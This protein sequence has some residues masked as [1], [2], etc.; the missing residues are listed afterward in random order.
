MLDLIS[1]EGPGHAPC[2]FCSFLL[3]SLALPGMGGER[4]WVRPSLPPLRMVPFSI[5]SPPFCLPGDFA[6]LLS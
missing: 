3:L 1:I 2:I 5:S 4:G 6:Y